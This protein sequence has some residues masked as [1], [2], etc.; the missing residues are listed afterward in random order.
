MINRVPLNTNVIFYLLFPC[1]F[2]SLLTGISRIE[3]SFITAILR[4]Y[5]AS[6]LY[7]LGKL[8]I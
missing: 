3:K 4:Y 5:I 1:S 7:V 8:S 6:R 2:T